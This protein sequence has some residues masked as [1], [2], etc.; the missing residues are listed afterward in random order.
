[1]ERFALA[2]RRFDEENSR[3]PNQGLVGDVARPRELLYAERLSRWV[4]A[5][6]PDASEVLR[7]A[8]RCQHLG[9]WR[10]PR[11]SQ[12]ATKAG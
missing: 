11:T 2:L 1:M 8:A 10:I 6:C 12:P 9:R 3:D 7:L 4:N 5:L